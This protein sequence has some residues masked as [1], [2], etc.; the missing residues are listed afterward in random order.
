MTTFIKTIMYG[1]MSVGKKISTES[2]AFINGILGE[3]L[4]EGCKIRDVR[5]QSHILSIYRCKA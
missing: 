3:I 2:D 4:S 5:I 1:P